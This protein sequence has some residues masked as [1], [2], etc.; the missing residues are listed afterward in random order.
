M[1]KKVRKNKMEIQHSQVQKICKK[2]SKPF[3]S[4]KFLAAG[5][6]N[7]CYLITTS[8]GKY[9]LKIEN[10]PGY[11]KREYKNLKLATHK[12]G[13]KIYFFDDSKKILK[14]PY[15]IQELL[16]GKHPKRKPDNEFV[17]KMAK[18]FKK[19]HSIKSSKIEKDEL[20]RIHDLT[21][22][23][24]LFYNRVKKAQIDF[25]EILYQKILAYFEKVLRI[26]EKN[27]HIFRRRKQFPLVHNDPAREN[28]FIEKSR[29]RLIDWEFAGFVIGERDLITF[30]RIYQLTDKQKTL[31][32]KTYGYPQSK[33]GKKQFQ[34]LT[35]LMICGDLCWLVERLEA[36]SKGKV[37]P[38]QQQR[39]KGKIVKKIKKVLKESKTISKI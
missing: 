25:D 26:C 17:I 39:D 5:G 9:V 29:V 14:R 4:Y 37:G 33:T 16:K 20:K 28:I 11:L 6:L 22:W 27:K 15:M 1:R 38:K 24:N 7:E 19:L 18:W 10:N 34:I 12:L 13:P 21:K 8:D 30:L 36:I 32:F 35:H 23:V 3:I 2:L 31:F